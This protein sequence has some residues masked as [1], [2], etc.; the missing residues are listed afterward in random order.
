MSVGASQPACCGAV[1]EARPDRW[2]PFDQGDAVMLGQER[3][4]EAVIR[5]S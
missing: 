3:L 5:S 2:H 4:R 1:A